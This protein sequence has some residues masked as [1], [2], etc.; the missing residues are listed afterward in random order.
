[1]QKGFISYSYW[2]GHFV[3]EKKQKNRNIL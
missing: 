3:C 1:M 2:L